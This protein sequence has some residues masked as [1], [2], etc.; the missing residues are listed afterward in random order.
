M[1]E[2]SADSSETGYAIGCGFIILGIII[3]IVFWGSSISLW[4]STISVAFGIT[5]AV[6]TLDDNND[7]K[8][9]Y[10]ELG[11]GIGIFSPSLL[12]LI[13]FSNPLAKIPFILIFVLGITL[14]IQGV[15]KLFK[16][17]QKEKS[18][19]ETSEKLIKEKA[20]NSFKKLFVAFF[21]VVALLS[22]LVTIVAFFIN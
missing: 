7:P 8:K 11:I 4:L 1:S 22:N 13:F 20:D 6:T 5:F 10:E 17:H 19:T 21:T 18:S 3:Q 16:I 14:A 12:G 9:G 15:I 2:K